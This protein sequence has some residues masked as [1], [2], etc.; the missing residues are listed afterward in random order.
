MRLRTVG[1]I[2][3]TALTVLV[4]QRPLTISAQ[5]PCEDEYTVQAGD[6]L[7]RIAEK[8]F[9]DV[10]AFDQI[11]QA[12][13]DQTDGKYADIENPDLIEPGW[14]LCIPPATSNE[15]S[16]EQAASGTEIIQ[17]DPTTVPLD[18]NQEL[19]VMTACQP[20]QVV[21]RPGVYQC[22]EAD[23]FSL[24]PCWVVEGNT[25]L[26]SPSWMPPQFEDPPSYT[27]ATAPDTLPEIDPATAETGPVAFFLALEENNPPCRKRADLEMVL[28]GQPVTYS[29]EAPGAWLVGELDTSQPTWLAQRVIADPSGVTVTDGPTTVGVQRAWVYGAVADEETQPAELERK[30]VWAD[31]VSIEVVGG[32]YV[33]T[34]NGH[35]PDSCSTLGDVES[36]V[37]GDTITITV[38]ADSP[39]GVSCASALVPFQ[40]SFTVDVGELEPGE[41]TVIVNEFATTTLTVN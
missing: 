7:S 1:I 16:M 24:D 27:L 21:P 5:S 19:R 28:A 11:V 12:T 35:F 8:F 13:N 25:L 30:Q 10:L 33:A 39:P 9:G 6:W 20:S 36:T 17:F 37:E 4:L 38:Y 14:V 32:Q 29:C 3:L 34:L 2:I 22:T 18:P 15:E 26:C 40:T 31:D 23:G 41:Y